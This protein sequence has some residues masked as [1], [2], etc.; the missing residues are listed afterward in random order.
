MKEAYPC[1]INRS[2][3]CTEDLINDSA[4]NFGCGGAVPFNSKSRDT[5]SDPRYPG[6]CAWKHG[7]YNRMIVKLYA[8]D[9]GIYMGQEKDCP[10]QNCPLWLEDYTDS[11]WDR[12]VWGVDRYHFSRRYLTQKDEFTY[13]PQGF[14]HTPKQEDGETLRFR[15]SR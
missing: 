1:A 3:L 2:H 11:D 7:F 15:S 4:P 8:G 12:K 6:I 14:V 9:I 10:Q 5:V 13:V